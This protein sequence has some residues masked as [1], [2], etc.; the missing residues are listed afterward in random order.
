MSYY[1]GFELTPGSKQVWGS[2]GSFIM[3]VALSTEI[4]LEFGAHR[5]AAYLNLEMLP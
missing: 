5:Q 3:A 1:L 4:E 2:A